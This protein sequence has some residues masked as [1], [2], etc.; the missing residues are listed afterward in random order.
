MCSAHE[1][2]IVKKFFRKEIITP[3][4]RFNSNSNDQQRVMS[5]KNAFQNGSE[6]LV[7]G[8]PITQGNIKLNIE[9]LI[10]HLKND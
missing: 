2:K 10:N 4:I 1:V 6:W 8:R 3:G 7:M 5:P 9:K